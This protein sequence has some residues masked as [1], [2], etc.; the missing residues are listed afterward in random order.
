ME[1]CEIVSVDGMA[2]LVGIGSSEVEQGSIRRPDGARW[3]VGR[4]TANGEVQYIARFGTRY[5]T[6]EEFAREVA[7]ATCPATPGEL[8]AE[9]VVLDCGEQGYERHL[10]R[11]LPQAI[12][13]R[14]PGGGLLLSLD[15]LVDGSKPLGERYDGATAAAVFEDLVAAVAGSAVPAGAAGSATTTGADDPAAPGGSTASDDSAI[16]AGSSPAPAMAGDPEG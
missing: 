13:D 15:M 16:Q 7:A 12:A 3:C 1:P 6:S 2:G 4:A 11:V 10:V 9:S 5:L 14:D 8:G